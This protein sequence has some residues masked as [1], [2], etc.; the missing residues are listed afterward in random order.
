MIAAR[1]L[2]G[3]GGHDLR[4]S[5]G[6]VTN[7]TGLTVQADNVTIKGL[8]ITGGQIGIR[9]DPGVSGLTVQCNYIG[10]APD[11]TGA[12][13]RNGLGRSLR[14]RENSNVT[15]GGPNGADGNVIGD[16]NDTGIFF[17]I[18]GSNI[19]VQNNF[20]GTDPTG[21]VARTNNVTGV[22]FQGGSS[23]TVS[24]ISNNLIS[25]NGGAGI[26]SA[27]TQMIDAASGTWLI[28]GNTIGA[29]RTATAA[30]PNGT[31]GVDLQ[32][33]LIINLT[34]GGTAAGDRNIISGN[35]ANG[36]NFVALANTDILG[37]FIGVGSDGSTALSNGGEGIFVFV[38][39]G[40]NIGNGT[41]GGRNVIS[42]N[43]SFGLSTTSPSNLTLRGNYVG[44]NAAGTAA[45]GNS[46]SGIL[47][48]GGS[49]TTIG[50]AST[51]EGNL[52]AGN[53]QSGIVVRSSAS[54]V[55]VEGNTI[56][57]AADQN[58]PLGNGHSGVWVSDASSA[59]IFDNLIGNNGNDGVTAVDAG[60]TAAIY[61]NEIVN[62]TDIGIDVVSNGVSPNDVGDADAGPNDLLNFPVLTEVRSD[63]TTSIEI[64]FTLDVP[65]NPT[66]GYRI[67][68]FK[69][70]AADSSGHG[71]GEI[72]LGFI[73][74]THGGG[75]LS[76]T[77]QTLTA[78]EAVSSSDIISAT[79]TRKTGPSTY[80]ITSEF[81][82]NRK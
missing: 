80:D 59:S 5:L 7:G 24:E 13:Q 1:D 45:L 62:N 54:D 29:N 41:T 68:F 70:T 19:S 69:N 3:G 66:H 6:V 40:V 34:L 58:T 52:V 48:S 30:L 22:Y 57:F 82:A 9:S 25:G 28:Q 15:I 73:D 37:N 51:G 77:G 38:S 81:S 78:N 39:N 8:S 56:G 20:I 18:G 71:E 16:S 47:I 74:I 42:G 75:N 65:N 23:F 79:A 43:G 67:D 55:V 53:A 14:I 44:T 11:G 63:G 33:G 64:D 10:I 61:A 35:T 72:H 2:W 46:A 49:G 60:T 12:G 4:V 76:F 32:G 26:G 31:H 50:G 36:L 21:T 17:W 27:A